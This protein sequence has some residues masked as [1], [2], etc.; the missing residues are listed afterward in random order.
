MSSGCDLFVS[1]LTR[2]SAIWTLCPSNSIP[3]QPRFS[4]MEAIAVVPPPRNGSRTRSF[5]FVEASKQRSTSATGFCVGWRP[6]CFSSFPG[7]LSVHI[8]LSDKSAFAPDRLGA[9]GVRLEVSPAPRASC[10]APQ[11]A[12]SPPTSA[13]IRPYPAIKKYE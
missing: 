3:T 12:Q 9:L 5:S 2:F 7:A 1:A 13:H 4:L 10:P 11:S 6:N 8:E